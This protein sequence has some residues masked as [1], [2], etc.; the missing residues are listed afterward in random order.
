MKT[1]FHEKKDPVRHCVAPEDSLNL[2]VGRSL[3]VVLLMLLTSFRFAFR[4]FFDKGST[5]SVTPSE[6]T[7]SFLNNFT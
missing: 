4:L 6:K 1:L 7:L 3:F 2:F 5:L